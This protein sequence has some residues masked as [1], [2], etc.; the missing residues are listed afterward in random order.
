MDQSE[1]KKQAAYEAVK[2]VRPGMVVG[3]GTGSTAIW[4]TRR[5][6]ELLAAGKLTDII[7]IPTSDVTAREARSLSI[8]LSTLETHRHIDLTIDGADEIDPQLNLIKGGGGA[9]YMERKVA[10]ASKQFVVVADESKL[11]PCLGT[12][13]YVPVQ[14][15]V[16][17]ID[18]VHGEL[19]KLGN[20]VVR[21][22][23]DVI[24]LTDQGD[25]II[26]LH[27]GPLSGTASRNERIGEYR[28]NSSQLSSK[29][30]QLPGVVDH[31]LFIG[32]NPKIIIAGEN[33]ITLL[34]AHIKQS[35]TSSC[36]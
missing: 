25:A 6:G 12:R 24:F 20:A 7:G 13:F 29:L 3:L 16:S 18:L 22:S 21:K 4:A 5:I 1:L 28:L 26:D 31:G 32:M 35:G 10:R 36:T 30:S 17:Q 33:G 8:P 19:S 9:L 23:G 15:G 34:E 2:L 11:S 27:C 14:V